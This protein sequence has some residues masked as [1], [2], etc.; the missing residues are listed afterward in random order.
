MEFIFSSHFFCMYVKD[1]G[2]EL[3]QG[4]LRLICNEDIHT[5]SAHMLQL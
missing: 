2:T 1:S 4:V 5:H 3:S